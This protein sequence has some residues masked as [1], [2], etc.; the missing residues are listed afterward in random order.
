MRTLSNRISRPVSI[1]RNGFPRNGFV[2][3]AVSLVIVSCATGPDLETRLV[4]GSRP[5]AD[6]MRDAGRKPAAVMEFL[7]VE[8]GMTAIDVIASGGYYTDV[9]AEAV[10]PEGKV[11]AQ[12][13]AFVLQIRDG[14]NEKAMAARLAGNRLPN[15][16]RLDREL[17][18]LGL[19]PGSV[20]V[21]FS[22]LNF[23]DIL[24]GRGPDAAAAVLRAIHLV[25]TDDGVFGLVDH[26]GDPGEEHNA[27]NKE[28]HRI[29][30]A[31]VIEAVTTAG[32]VVEATSDVLRNPADDRS[33]NV[34]AEDT[35]GRTDRFVLKLRKAN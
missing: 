16:V 3:A 20:D 18:D 14:V 27:R 29:D 30:E 21:A 2:V 12:N 24:D 26:A 23:H 32:F 17:D 19:A 28:L 33:V 34:F 25:L 35:R 10:G 8:P 9:L 6:K 7:G 22:A 4:T 31:R 15:V 13:I 5:V 1:Q 11:Y